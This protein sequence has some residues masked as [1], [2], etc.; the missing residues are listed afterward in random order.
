MAK[1][2]LF[3]EIRH[4][5]KNLLAVT[6]SI[7]RHTTT[8]GRTAKQFR[9]DFLGRFGALVEAQNLALSKSPCWQSSS[10]G[11]SRPTGHPL[12]CQTGRV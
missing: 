6:Q 1:D 8:N 4:R 3:G 11:F 7:A 10:N 5:M 2:M 12:D 9:D